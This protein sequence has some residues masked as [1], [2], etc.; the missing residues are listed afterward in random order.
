MAYRAGEVLV[1]FRPEVTEG[2]KNAL[3]AA[4]GARRGKQLRGASRF[5]RL[6]I[7]G[8]QTPQ[9]LAQQLADQAAVEWVEPNYLINRDDITPN[10]ARFNE[11]WSLHKTGNAPGQITGAD[12][13][14]PS[15][16]ERTTGST[17]TVIARWSTTG[18]DGSGSARRPSR[19]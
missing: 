8:G 14:A 2:E 3:A 6:E 19:V 9:L 15:A 17:A 5:E 1:P 4:R 16:W 7:L 13:A 11:Q 10:D 12:I 18:T